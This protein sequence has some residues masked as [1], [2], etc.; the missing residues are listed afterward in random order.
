MI[1]RYGPPIFQ[2]LN[3]LAGAYNVALIKAIPS[4]IILKK[5]GWFVLKQETLF[6]FVEKLSQRSSGQTGVDLGQLKNYPIPLPP[7]PEQT[8]IASALSDMD[9]LIAQTEKL[10]EKKKAIKQGVMQE[11]LN[12]K[13]GWVT[14]KLGDVGKC[15]RGVSYNPELDLHPFSNEF[16]YTLLRS[17]NIFEGLLDF[18]NLQFV[19]KTRVKNHQVIKEMDIVICMA[20]G[21]KQL[22]GKSALAENVEMGKFTFGAFMGCFRSFE[23]V[24][25]KFI[26]SLMESKKYRDY[27]DVLLSGSSINNLN[28]VN[29]ESIEFEF[30]PLETQDEITR[31]IDSLRI[32]LSL[33]TSKLQKLKL[34]KQGIMQALLTG[35]IRLA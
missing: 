25:P 19:D 11:L 20:N 28:P 35:K 22:V 4:A 1:G 12:P 33:L 21:S 3:G 10:I 26:F 27:I 16:N 34:Q 13:E 24:N 8:A 6:D 7:L 31:I 2:I 23:N 14:R 5:F 29:I 17:N 18:N 32:E 15:L 30:P 9:A